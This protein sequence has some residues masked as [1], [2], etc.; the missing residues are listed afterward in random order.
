MLAVFIPL[1]EE[2]KAVRRRA[3][4]RWRQI[5]EEEEGWRMG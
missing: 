1:R 5:G 4:K 2:R 3:E